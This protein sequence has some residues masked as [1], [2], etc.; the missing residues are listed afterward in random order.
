MSGRL[1]NHEQ[2][3]KN[4]DGYEEDV[5]E[6]ADEEDAD[7]DAVEEDDDTHVVWTPPSTGKRRCA[8][9]G[10][11]AE[12]AVCSHECRRQSHVKFNTKCKQ[13]GKP[14]QKIFNF[15]YCSWVCHANDALVPTCG[16]CGVRLEDCNNSGFDPPM[17]FDCVDEFYYADS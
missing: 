1:C 13:C 17:C 14:C 3:R 5:D 11:R 9:C 7:E 15:E 2:N 4:D 10:K 8:I 16:L 12:G 6:D